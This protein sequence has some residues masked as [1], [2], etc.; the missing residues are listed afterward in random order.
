MDD[1]CR[2][3]TRTWNLDFIKI[4]YTRNRDQYTRVNMADGLID[5]V[6]FTIYSAVAGFQTG[7]IPHQLD[8]IISINGDFQL[9]VQGSDVLL[10]NTASSGNRKVGTLINKTL[11]VDLL[12]LLLNVTGISEARYLLRKDIDVISLQITGEQNGGEVVCHLKPFLSLYPPIY[13]FDISF[14]LPEDD[15]YT[16]DDFVKLVL[17]TSG[18]RFLVKAIRLID[19]YVRPNPLSGDR[20]M[21]SHCYTVV[22]QSL[23]HAL[24]Y[25]QAY[26]YYQIMRN[27]CPSFLD[28][29]LR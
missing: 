29:M 17:Y 18:E 4:D 7:E 26:E 16:I 22:Y 13:S 5:S 10:S 24:S 1:L 3:L 6:D 11:S 21:I 27:S 23:T 28:V 9:S 20:R 8:R 12:P 25:L 2:V 15:S 14:W 19:I